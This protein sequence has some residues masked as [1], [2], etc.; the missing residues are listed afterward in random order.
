MRRVNRKIICLFGFTFILI[1]SLFSN[2]DA[3]QCNRTIVAD[4]VALDQPIFYNRLGTFNPIGMM[5]ALRRDVIDVR[6]GTPEGVRNAQGQVGVLTPGFVQLRPDKRPRPI[7][8]RMN[9]GDCL[10]INF[11]NLLSPTPA[12]AI[13]NGVQIDNQPVTRAAGI[14]VNGMQPVGSIL[15]DGSN[16]GRNSQIQPGP[17]GLNGLVVPGQSITYRFYAEFENTYLLYNMGSTTGAEGMGGTTAF[18]LFGAVNVEPR[19]SEWY[20]SQVTREEMDLATVGRTPDGHPIINYDARYPNREPFIT[21]GKVRRGIGLPILRMLDGNQIVHSDLNAIITGPNRG[22]FLPGTHYPSTPVNP[23]QQQPFR[24]FTVIFHDEI[25]ALQAFPEFFGNPT[26]RH[27]LHGVRDTFAINYGTGGIGSEIIAN[28][29][30]LGPMWDCN[31]C[32]YEEFFLTSWVVADPGMVVDIPANAGPIVNGQ[33]VPGARATVAFYPDDPALVHHSYINDHVKIRN[34]HAGPAEHHMFHLHSHQ[35]VFSPM[36]DKS[37]YLDGQAVGPGSGYTYDIAFGGSGNRNKTPGDAIFHCHFYP[38]FAQGMWA[39]WRNHDVFEEGTRLEVQFVSRFRNGGRAPFALGSAKPAPG[40]RALPDGEIAAG[41]PIPAVVPIPGL[42]MPPMPGRAT[43]MSQPGLPG[44]QIVVT[45]PDNDG[46]GIPDRN[47]GFP[48]FIA[49][50]AGHRPPTPPLDLIDDGGLPRHI[51]VGPLGANTDTTGTLIRQV[52]SRIDFS[53]ELLKADALQIPEEGTPAEKAAMNFHSQKFH[54]SFKPDGTPAQ[55]RTNGRPPKRGAPY[56]DPCM[57]DNGNAL[58][59]GITPFFTGQT[60]QTP[61]TIQ[62]GAEN[63]RTYK[64]ANIQTDV[65]FNKV[66]WHHPQQRLITLWED[67]VPTL[68][69]QRP[70][71]PFVMRLN[72]NDCAEYWHTNLVPSYYELDDYQVRTPTDVIGQHIHLVKFDV[73]SSDGSANGFNYEDGTFS[74]DEVR[75]RIHA[76]NE[77]GGL[78][79]YE[80]GDRIQLT[81]RPH[82][83]FGA[84]PNGRWLGARTTVQRWFA[85]PILDNEGRD[86]TLGMVF[87]HDHFGPSSH[88]QTGLYATL[89]V[90]PAGSTWRHNET[91]TLLGNRHDGGPTSWQAVILG[92]SNQLDGPAF[93]EFLLE[94]G[95][96]QH[97]YKAN[98]PGTIG[99]DSYL[100]AINPSFRVEA[101]NATAADPGDILEFPAICPDGVNVRPCPEAI[102]ADDVGTMVLNYR[103]E[104]VGLRIFDPNKLNPRTGTPGA[105]ADGLAGDLAFALSS[106][107]SINRAI[108]ELNNPMPAPVRDSSVVPQ[109]FG[110]LNTG[111]TIGPPITGPQLTFDVGPKDP[112]TPILRVYDGD[113]IRVRIQT[114]ATEESHNFSI[115]G[116]KW[117]QEFANFNSGW[118][119]TQHLGIDEQF[120]FIVPFIGDPGQIGNASD[121]LYTANASGDGYW[122]G[123]WGIIRAYNRQRSDLYVLPNNRLGTR[124]HII[125]NR[126][127]FLGNDQFSGTCPVTAPRRQ[128]DITAVRAADVLLENPLLGIS[129]LVY[130]SR[131]SVIPDIVEEGNLFEGGSGPLHDPTALLYVLTGD[132]DPVTGKLREGVPVEPLILRAN[133]GDCIE[134]TLRNNLPTTVPDLPGWRNLQAIIDR[135]VTPTGKVTF[136]ANDIIPSSHVGLHVQLLEYDV[137]RA[138]GTNVGRNPIQTA[139]PG[140]VVRYRWY[141]GDLRLRRIFGNVSRLEATPVEFGVV[142]LLPADKIEQGDKGLVGA[143][144]ILPQGATWTEDPN[145]RASATVQAGN[146]TFRDF[147]AVLQKGTQFRYANNNPV[148]MVGGEG[149]MGEDSEDTG[150]KGINYRSEPLWFRLGFPPHLP[151]EDQRNFFTQ[152]VYANAQ[153]TP[154]ADP[155]TPIFR[156][157]ALTPARFRFVMPT[158]A[159]TRNGVLTLH[160]HLWEREP[161]NSNPNIKGPDR[162]A[163]NPTSQLTG[164]QEGIGPTGHWDIIPVH[165]AGGA[166]GITGDYLYRMMDSFHNFDGMWGIFRVE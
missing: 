11:T 74:P 165:G 64:G 116:M 133:A 1:F 30:G 62:Y 32:K 13:V 84:G 112:A 17:S 129:T 75:E 145:T 83:F 114:G 44:S 79:P 148:P 113:N 21:E 109:P 102:S 14:H 160:G 19:G 22:N 135:E 36:N 51:I 26:F 120:Q 55:F 134:V 12:V 86:R 56:A 4:V 35:W 149:R 41:T 124:G 154:A 89:I 15:S 153:L 34:L 121:Y 117:L 33:R 10:Q 6:T 77:A 139:P 157:N 2:V 94:W 38:H 163:S 8:L 115:H 122:N 111:Y 140:G 31:D 61:K 146:Q 98:W 100:Y 156:A 3:Q 46:D 162:I 88:Q 110:G 127:E 155:E 53:K 52:T 57:D 142:G 119:N 66:G 128:F 20:R 96:F 40:S 141:A 23:E 97:A 27:T 144:V 158:G 76:I 73:T 125:Q 18:G 37:S 67:V 70:P 49:G 107:A 48:F 147:V 16:V 43:V 131:P 103:N 65:I 108:P 69:G 132:I 78:I 90:E 81:A 92:G 85:D 28:R 143:M 25:F 93:R 151:P 60:S 71:E 9:S 105:Q 24:E 152:N 166:F 68:S 130:N 91:G 138:D 42:P 118:R 99:P 101:A 63:P 45:E 39:L 137:T 150:S 7:V 82:P 80:G 164:S 72:T 161:Y 87:T 5:Y 123:V 104:P 95:D 50:I 59:P 159:G 126:S 47:P 54:S 136:N 29:L 106:S 58:L